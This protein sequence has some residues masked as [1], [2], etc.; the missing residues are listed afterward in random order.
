ML[1]KIFL[2]TLLFVSTQLVAQ[3]PVPQEVAEMHLLFSLP[4]QE[5]KLASRQVMKNKH[6][7]YRYERKPIAGKT[8][9]SIPAVSI[10]V[11]PRPA[12]QTISTYSTAR[13]ATIKKQK[14]FR[15][16][17]VFTNSDGMLKLPYA[18]G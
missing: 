13:L 1:K 7:V 3:A 10:I 14:N 6:I 2:F 17:K 16:Q 12:E 18:I 9:K 8:N 5:W 4:N 15:E 11:E